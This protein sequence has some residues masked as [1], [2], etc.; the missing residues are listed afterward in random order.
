MARRMRVFSLIVVLLAAP[1]VAGPLVIP[2]EKATDTGMVRQPPPP[3]PSSFPASPDP[4]LFKDGGFEQ[5]PSSQP[6]K[7]DAMV[8]QPPRDD[9]GEVD[10]DEDDKPKK[11]RPER[12]RMKKRRFVGFSVA[13]HGGFFIRGRNDLARI[14]NAIGPAGEPGRLGGLMDGELTLDIGRHLRIGLSVI[15]TQLEASGSGPDLGAINV[16]QNA[17]YR[18]LTGGL[19]VD[20][21]IPLSQSVDLSLG[22]TLAAGELNVAIF[23]SRIEDFSDV[24]VDLRAIPKA[25]RFELS[26]A[27][28]HLRPALGFRLKLG[29]RAFAAIDIRLGLDVYYVPKNTL[30]VADDMPLQGSPEIIDL[31]PYLTVGLALGDF[32]MRR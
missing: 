26:G 2:P 32:G 24:G 18:F 20:G 3:G 11:R 4:S 31:H 5:Q 16:R 29:Q 28:L 27:L 30:R 17:R 12:Y 14:G 13:A 1:A 22:A 25:Q 8:R 15:W 9:D 6:Y 21:V 7:D 19:I 10:D 23:T